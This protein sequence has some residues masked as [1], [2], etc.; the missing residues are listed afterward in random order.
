MLALRQ[1]PAGGFVRLSTMCLTNTKEEKCRCERTT[2]EKEKPM[3]AKTLRQTFLDHKRSKAELKAL[4]PEDAKEAFGH[5][6]RGKRSKSG[7]VSFDLL[8]VEASHAAVQ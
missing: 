5:G 4:M 1:K 3:D 7:A 6:V 2:G 8:D